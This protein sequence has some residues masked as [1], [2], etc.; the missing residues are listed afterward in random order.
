MKT[1]RHEFENKAAAG[2]DLPMLACPVRQLFQA[3]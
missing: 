3:L 2:T 1:T